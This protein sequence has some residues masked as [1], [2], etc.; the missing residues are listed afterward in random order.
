MAFYKNDNG[1]LLWSLDRVLNDSFELWADKKYTYAYPVQGWIWADTEVEARLSLQCYGIQQF[2]S[3][4]V[5]MQTAQW[6]A[7]TP[8]PNEEGK[9]YYW[10]EE[11]LN[12]QE[13]IV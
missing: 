2:P 6:E 8:M 9:G 1:M 3:W 4:T 11:D 7:P 10:V 13:L 12:W 5:N